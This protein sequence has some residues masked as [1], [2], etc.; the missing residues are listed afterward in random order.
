MVFQSNLKKKKLT[1]VN[2]PE[3]DLQDTNRTIREG[4]HV[5]IDT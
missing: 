5:V 4:Q 1:I 3:G 2:S